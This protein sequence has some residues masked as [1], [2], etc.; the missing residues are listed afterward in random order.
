MARN[1]FLQELIKIKKSNLESRPYNQ[2]IAS[3]ETSM[4]NF[5]LLVF[6]FPCLLCA[7]KKD[8]HPLTKLN[9]WFQD[10][11][12]P[13][14][15]R[16]HKFATLAS[17]SAT[18]KPYTRVVELVK[19]SPQSGLVFFTHKNSI[20]VGHFSAN[21]HAALNIYLPK[22]GRQISLAGKVFP[23][24]KEDVTKAW[25]RMPRSLKLATLLSDHAREATS[26]KALEK[27]KQALQTRYKQA[28][29]PAPPTFVGF[30]F[31]PEEVIFF[32]IRRGTFPIKEIAALDEH[33]RWSYTL[34]DP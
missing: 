15:G 7:A 29:I 2:L 5:V 9:Q 19:V 20:K 28:A 6:I 18:N 13:A 8:P 22:T 1:E 4:K 16:L 33:Q 25:R 32:Q 14:G 30:S 26:L 27:R 10:E 23:V 34:V 31:H 3:S 21:P 11:Q 24:P 17:V 12:D